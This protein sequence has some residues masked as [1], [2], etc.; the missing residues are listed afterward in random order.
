[1]TFL[2]ELILLATLGIFIQP[3]G[4]QSIGVFKENSF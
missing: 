4:C 2:P 3:E 1:M